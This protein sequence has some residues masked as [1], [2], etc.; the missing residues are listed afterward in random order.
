MMKKILLVIFLISLI[1]VPAFPTNWCEDDDILGCWPFEDGGTGTTVQDE[2]ANELDF[3]VVAGNPTWGSTSPPVSTSTYYMDFDGSGDYLARAGIKTWHDTSLVQWAKPDTADLSEAAGFRQ[4]DHNYGGEGHGIEK[5]NYGDGLWTYK[6]E[7]NGNN[8]TVLSDSAP[9]G[10][11]QHIAGVYDSDLGVMYM[12][13]DGV[14]QGSTKGIAN[15]TINTN[16]EYPLR[17]GTN[18]WADH[19][20]AGLIDEVAFFHMELDST[21]IDDIMSNG[22]A[23]AAATGA[24]PQIW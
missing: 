16:Q 15:G 13:V 18:P 10:T 23:Q 9:D 2:S 21:D 3:A 6:L 12:Y 19:D 20:Y 11:W 4:Y 7:I 5:S 14:I 8:D 24:P 17:I 1:C 22:L